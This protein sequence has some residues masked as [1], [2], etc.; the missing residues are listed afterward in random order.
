MSYYLDEYIEEFGHSG[1]L[2]WNPVALRKALTE[3]QYD[4]AEDLYEMLV[5]TGNNSSLNDV[6]VDISNGKYNLTD[7]ANAVLEMAHS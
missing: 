3:P 5:Y 6:L 4:G 2:Y 7:V 1:L